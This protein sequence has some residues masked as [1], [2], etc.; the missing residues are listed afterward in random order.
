MIEDKVSKICWNDK[1]WKFP[2]GSK[3]KSSASSSFESNYRY[4]HEEWLFDKY[5]IIDNYHYAFLQP[6]NLKSDKHVGKTYNIYLFT[7][8]DGIKYFVGQIKNAVCVSKDESKNIYGIYKKKG[9]LKEMVKQI[10]RAGADPKTFTETSPEH[11]FNVKFKFEDVIK[12]DE[13][14]EIS[15][16]DL[17]ITTTRYK[18]LPKS[19]DFKIVPENSG[20]E[21]EGKVKSII[22]RNRTYK[23]ETSF[24]PYHDKMQ[25]ALYELLKNEFKNEYK[26]VLLEKDRVDIKAKTNAEKWHYFE[27]KTDSPKLSIRS[28]LGQIMEY[29]Y[30]PDMERAEKLI[31]VSDDTP[32]PET[33]KYLEHI[34]NKFKI[35]VFYRSFDIQKNVLSRDY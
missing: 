35:P 24:D 26:K 31:I 18:L 8:T 2:S 30:W 27:I 3:G 14:N 9:W 32:N 29:S 10:E 20:D 34:R 19:N 11:F 15:N 17:N 25:N 4:G 21:N 22:R 7:I 28:A 6:L 13:L 5:H 16:Q 1:G 12:H 33:I 23:V